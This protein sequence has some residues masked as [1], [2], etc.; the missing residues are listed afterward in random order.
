[1]SQ[2]AAIELRP[3]VM[4]LADWRDV[5]RGA[6]LTLDP[7]ARADVEAGRAAFA[8]VLNGNRKA[9][10]AGS[11]SASPSVA[12]LVDRGGEPLPASLLRLF[13]ALKLASLAQGASGIRWNVLE[14]LA[15]FLAHDLLPV[16]SVENGS[17]R[18]AL[19][20]L[21]GALT[22]TGEALR[23][24]R[25]GPAQKA[26]KQAGLKPLKLNAHERS[27]FLTGTQL[28]IAAAARRAF[29]GRARLP[30]GARRGCAVERR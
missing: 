4:P 2:G 14:T 5:Y 20:R 7:I 23:A 1:M 19:A 8:E 22:G 15:E 11:G 27:A 6:P 26:L 29:R 9:P 16:V 21:F 18:L 25:T 10:A 28:S 12:E 30:V 17:D 24:G 13:T 3:G